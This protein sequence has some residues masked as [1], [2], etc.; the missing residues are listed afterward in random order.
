MEQTHKAGN[1]S[2]GF[3]PSSHALVATAAFEVATQPRVA[4]TTE[5]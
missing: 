3:A 1:L 4:G 2:G 5:V